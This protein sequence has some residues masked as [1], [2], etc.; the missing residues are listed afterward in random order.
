MSALRRKSK[1]K[2]FALAA[3][4]SLATI[5]LLEGTCFIASRVCFRDRVEWYEQFVGNLHEVLQPDPELLWRLSSPGR[6]GDVNPLGFRGPA[7]PLDFQERKIVLFMGDSAVFGWNLA[8]EDCICCQL[9]KHLDRHSSGEYLVVN[10]GVPGYSS[11]QILLYFREIVSHIRPHLVLTY[12]GANDCWCEGN[13][14]RDS[15]KL[16]QYSPALRL[17]GPLRRSSVLRA[18][19]LIRAEA[20]RARKKLRVSPQEYQ[21]NLDHIAELAQRV[22]AAY[23]HVNPAYTNG[24]RY[25]SHPKSCCEP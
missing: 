3:A 12:V 4:M 10:A 2:L 16:Q 17:L 5:V 6:A 24:R 7:F 11:H 25:F 1:L 20:G 9:Q 18:F 23:L 15:E 13:Y 8:C 21:R 19:R 22:G 14:F